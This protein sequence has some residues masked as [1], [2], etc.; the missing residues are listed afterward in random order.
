MNLT[1]PAVETIRSWLRVNH[2]TN[3]EIMEATGLGLSTVEKATAALRLASDPVVANH[4]RRTGR[5]RTREGLAERLARERLRLLKRQNR[6]AAEAEALRRE[7][8]RIVENALAA[9][10]LLER[11]WQ[12]ATA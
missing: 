8:V 12:G 7:A 2:G 6:E 1:A 3:A 10:T 5:G 4:V 9:R 11:A